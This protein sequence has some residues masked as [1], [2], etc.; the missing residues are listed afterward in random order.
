MISRST[1]QNGTNFICPFRASW[2]RGK[3][4]MFEN[5]ENIPHRHLRSTISAQRPPRTRRK[6][7]RSTRENMENT[8]RINRRRRKLSRIRS[9]GTPGFNWDLCTSCKKGAAGLDAQGEH[10]KYSSTQARRREYANW[11]WLRGPSV[12]QDTDNSK[13]EAYCSKEDTKRVGPTQEPMVSN[14]FNM[15]IGRKNGWF[16]WIRAIPLVSLR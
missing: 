8:S 13:C 2:P 9:P 14:L 4:V 6:R 10:T 16:H 11:S 15:R 12:T 1:V 5:I 7:H 3:K